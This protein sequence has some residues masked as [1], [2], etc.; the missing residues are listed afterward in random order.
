MSTQ[1][2]QVLENYTYVY[3]YVAFTQYYQLT[4][5]IFKIFILFYYCYL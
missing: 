1:T 2:F 4:D 3:T 5:A